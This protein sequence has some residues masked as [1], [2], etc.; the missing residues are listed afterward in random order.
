[1]VDSSGAIAIID[2]VPRTIRL[3]VHLCKTISR[4]KE[5]NKLLSQRN[6]CKPTEE[7]IATRMEMTIE[8]AVYC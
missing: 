2:Q 7:E 8:A 3:P 6:G 4:I 5:N 1:M